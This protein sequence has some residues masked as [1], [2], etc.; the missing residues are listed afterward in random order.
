MQNTQDFWE[1]A[2][3]TSLPSRTLVSEEYITVKN[4][5]KLIIR[6]LISNL[7]MFKHDWFRWNFRHWHPNIFIFQITILPF[8]IAAAAV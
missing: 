7:K 6:L 3:I 5:Q 2:E 4:K 1:S 8:R